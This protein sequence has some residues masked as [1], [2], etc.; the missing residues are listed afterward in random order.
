MTIEKLQLWL[1]NNHKE[2]HW[3]IQID[4]VALGKR[5]TLAEMR[6]FVTNKKKTKA[7]IKV[8]HVSKQT[9]KPRPWITLAY[10]RDSIEPI[11]S[12][13]RP[14]NNPVSPKTPLPQVT[15]IINSESAKPVAEQKKG[16]GFF[17][18]LKPEVSGFK[19][20]LN[21]YFSFK[22]Q[23]GISDEIAGELLKTFAVFY[24]QQRLGPPLIRDEYRMLKMYNCAMRT[25]ESI[26]EQE[27]GWYL[28]T[29]LKGLL[30]A[31]G[32]DWRDI[33]YTAIRRVSFKFQKIPH[34]VSGL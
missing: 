1:S 10:K 12:S 14:K 34:E 25:A 20:V 33:D 21:G 27:G 23:S 8:L 30:A 31:E 16:F 29:I 9:E 26:V 5:L 19:N 24:Y 6:E 32:L 2:D 15:K 18:F 11:Q 7:I 17:D 3:W 4:G 22:A 13:E 28:T